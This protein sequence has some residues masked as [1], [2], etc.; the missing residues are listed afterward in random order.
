MKVIVLPV[1]TP[2]AELIHVLLVRLQALE[3]FICRV[4]I[5]NYHAGAAEPRKTKEQNGKNLRSNA[6]M[7]ACT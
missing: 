5:P 1:L 4:R 7:H 6:Y 2:E 3:A